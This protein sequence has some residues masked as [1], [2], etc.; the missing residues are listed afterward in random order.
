MKSLK[1]LRRNFKITKMI[2]TLLIS[3]ICLNANKEDSLYRMRAWLR[4]R[5]IS[6]IR[7]LTRSLTSHHCKKTLR[8]NEGN[9]WM[10]LGQKDR[11][12]TSANTFSAIQML[13]LFMTFWIALLKIINFNLSQVK[14]MKTIFQ[15]L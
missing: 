14:I 9:Q 13:T 11:N 6:T 5:M 3:K 12:P 10:R 2:S 8:A 4:E 15:L 7:I 1:N